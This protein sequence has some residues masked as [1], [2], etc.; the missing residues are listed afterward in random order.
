MP[1]SDREIQVKVPG[2]QAFTLRASYQDKEPFGW[3][4]MAFV[5]DNLEHVIM[6]ADFRDSVYSDPFECLGE[7][8]RRLTQDAESGETDKT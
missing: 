8:I 7:A 3:I 6:A 5:K 4:A 1:A 2:R